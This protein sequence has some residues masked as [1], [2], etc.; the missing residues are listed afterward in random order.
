MNPEGLWYLNLILVGAMLLSLYLLRFQKRHPTPLNLFAR[1]Q[2]LS[3]GVS[4]S[5]PSTA[6]A[7]IA[8]SAATELTV[9]FNYNGHSWEAHE[10]LGVP[11]GCSESIARGAHAHLIRGLGADSREFFDLAL[12]A[13]LSRNQRSAS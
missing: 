1:R 8:R 10:A 6:A 13:I 2:P 4:Q 9:M 3:E 11:A 5:R 12:S 7:A